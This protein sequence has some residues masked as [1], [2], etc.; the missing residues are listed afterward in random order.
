MAWH[1]LAWDVGV[2]YELG[3]WS[4]LQ[5]ERTAGYICIEGDDV[6]DALEAGSLGFLYFI[7]LAFAFQEGMDG[8]GFGSSQQF[9]FIFTEEQQ[10]FKDRILLGYAWL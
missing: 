4:F 9:D 2:L 6:V 8:T 3:I 7:G 10:T 1:G 5:Q